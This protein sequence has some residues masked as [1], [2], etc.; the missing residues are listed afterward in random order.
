MAGGAKQLFVGSN[1]CRQ[2]LPWLDGSDVKQ[3]GALETIFVEHHLTFGYWERVHAFPRRF[4]D[5]MNP[6]GADAK[7]RDRL[8]FRPGAWRDDACR[9]SRHD[10]NPTAP[11]YDIRRFVRHRMSEE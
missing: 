2:V 7:V 5:D 8:L 9:P 4:V 10:R 6:I 1:E 3:I 11:T